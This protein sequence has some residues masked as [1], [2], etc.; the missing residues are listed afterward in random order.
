MGFGNQY[1]DVT[2]CLSFTFFIPKKKILGLFNELPSTSSNP[3]KTQLYP[4]VLTQRLVNQ[5]VGRESKGTSP[6]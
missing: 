1:S 3:D 2:G 5:G 4:K 6:T